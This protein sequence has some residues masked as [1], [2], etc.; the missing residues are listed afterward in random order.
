M[1]DRN[2]YCFY[3]T[4]NG[5]SIKLDTLGY[6]AE[7]PDWSDTVKITSQ[8][9]GFTLHACTIWGGQED[10]VDINNMADGIHVMAEYAPQGKYVFTVKGG[11][12]G[13]LLIGR[14]IGSGTEVDV[15][16]GNWSD[17]CQ[18]RTTGVIMD[19]GK[20]DGSPVTVRVLNATKPTEVAGSGPYR[21]LFPHPDAWYHGLVV[22]AFRL[23][24]QLTK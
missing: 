7:R 5:Q 18:K 22:A 11:A 13:C 12:S 20:P 23:F 2:L 8:C 3:E 4:S 1:S 15:D 17:Q 9:T 10:C 14:I 24:C 16:L 21:Y 6:P 19:L